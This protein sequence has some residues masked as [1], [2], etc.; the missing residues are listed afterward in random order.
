V[1]RVLV[2]LALLVATMDCAKRPYTVTVTD[3]SSP[4]LLQRSDAANTRPDVRRAGKPS[5][6]QRAP[7]IRDTGTP[8]GTAGQRDS[9]PE[10]T[11][12][13]GQ[14]AT[15]AERPGVE[16]PRGMAS[17]DGAGVPLDG[18]RGPGYG[19]AQDGPAPAWWILIILAGIA[20]AAAIR[21][22]ARRRVRS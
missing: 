14:P 7:A 4:R 11:G 19:A 16:E 8:T 1:G 3:R 13:T 22:S 12:G 9:L 6:D 20:A 18:S 17:D 21:A 15:S 5:G 2:V 10:L